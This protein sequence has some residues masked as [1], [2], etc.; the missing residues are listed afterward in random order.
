M[1]PLIACKLGQIILDKI[2]KAYGLDI[3][4]KITAYCGAKHEHHTYAVGIKEKIVF[5]SVL[6]SNNAVCNIK[7][8]LCKAMYSIVK[9]IH[10]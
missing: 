1:F 8:C 3:F 5:R 10:N 9:S 6:N 4:L 2:I 7:F